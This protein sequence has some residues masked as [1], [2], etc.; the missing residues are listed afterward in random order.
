MAGSGLDRVIALTLNLIAGKIGATVSNIPAIITDEALSGSHDF[1][2]GYAKKYKVNQLAALATDFSDSGLTYDAASAIASQTPKVNEFYVIKRATAVAAVVT[3]VFDANIVTGNTIAGTVNGSAIS[4]PFNTSNA[5]SLTDLATAIQALE[6]VAT[7]VSNGTTTI[8]ITFETQWEP[9]VS[10]FLV[11]LGAGQTTC[12]TTVATPATNIR[13]DIAAARAETA[14][15]EW[16]MLL[17]TTTSKGAILA[18]AAYVETLGGEIMAL[19]HTTD[20]AVITSA[21]TDVM[22]LL[23]DEAYEY[24]G[25]AYH[26][27]STEM[28]HAAEASRVFAIDPGKISFAL[29]SLA[30]CTSS[31]LT[32]AQIGYIEAKNGNCY[33]DAG[34][35]PL[36]LKGVNC[37]GISLEAVR[38]SLYAKAEL[39]SELYNLFTQRDKIP[40]NETGRSLV[41]SYA[42]GVVARMVAEGVFDPDASPANQFTMP[43]ISAISSGDRAA[44]LFP[45]CE[46]I[47][48]HL[49]GAIKIVIA[50]NISVA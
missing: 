39:E 33:T 3:L 12:V 44:R 32:P 46:L 13:D 50:A 22:S 1:G 27:D 25:I 14:T 45:D 18:A 47:A 26:D 24:S 17:P 37:N 23:Q 49:A 8:T 35:G 6:M 10:T 16:F 42:N 20:A 41:L 30:G 43:A 21:T 5:Q 40:Y 15:N 48:K 31:G 11:T 9:D 7:A 34:P 19:F 36:F 38:D 2:S 4:V 28:I 29:K